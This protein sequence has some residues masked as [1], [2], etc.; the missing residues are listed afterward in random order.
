MKTLHASD[1]YL[2]AATATVVTLFLAMI[3][4]L[5]VVGLFFFLLYC[6]ARALWAIRHEPEVRAV[7]FDPK[8]GITFR[9]GAT[10]AD[11]EYMRRL[12]NS[13]YAREHLQKPEEP[14]EPDD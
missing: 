12:F 10:P 7:N 13:M 9:G 11:I 6:A 4:Q 5:T 8:T 14:H 2:G 1:Y 3:S